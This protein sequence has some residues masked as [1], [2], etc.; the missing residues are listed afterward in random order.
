M[1]TQNVNVKTA[2]Q[3]SSRK[4]GEKPLTMS[5]LM[6][7]FLYVITNARGQKQPTF[8]VPPEKGNPVVA[9]SEDRTE[10]LIVWTL[11]GWPLAASIP[12]GGFLAVL[13]GMLE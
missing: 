5:Q 10:T 6:D 3:E 11:E 9:V 2:A 1:H 4:M 12:E 7:L 8:F 13:S